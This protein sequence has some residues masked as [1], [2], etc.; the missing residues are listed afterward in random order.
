MS[1][2]RLVNLTIIN[3]ENDICEE[4]SIKELISTFIKLKFSSYLNKNVILFKEFIVLFLKLKSF[5]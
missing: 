3:T 4:L 1:Q 5:K 2:E